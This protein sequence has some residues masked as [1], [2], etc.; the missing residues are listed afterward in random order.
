MHLS[1]RFN[2]LPVSLIKNHILH[3]MQLQVHLFDNM[4][5]TTR[6]TNDSGGKNYR[7]QDLYGR[8]NKSGRNDIYLV[9]LTCQGFHEEQ[10]TD[11]PFWKKSRNIYI[12]YTL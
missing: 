1:A 3:A 7:D 5:E 6:G 9:I 2:F 8:A 4:H 11:H 12:Y 10:Q